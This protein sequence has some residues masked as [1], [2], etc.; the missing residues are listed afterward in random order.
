MGRIVDSV[1][2]GITAALGQPPG[3]NHSVFDGLRSF[4]LEPDDFTSHF[5]Q[6]VSSFPEQATLVI[7]SMI[8]S[9]FIYGILSG[10]L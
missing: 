4:G 10:R 2:S 3:C 6:P 7:S 9:S 5:H 8:D 1:F